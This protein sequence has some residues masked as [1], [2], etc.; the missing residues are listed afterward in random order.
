MLGSTVLFLFSG[1][2]M[3]YVAGSIL[4]SSAFAFQSGT[5]SAFL[6]DTMS[7][8]KRE[9]DYARVSSANSANASFV[10]MILIIAL[11]FLTVVDIKWPFYIGL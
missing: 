6:H 8:L 11:P 9:K 5:F 10:S 4:L 3:G 7:N 2:F 1:S